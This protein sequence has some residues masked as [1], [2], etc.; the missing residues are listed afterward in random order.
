VDP[1]VTTFN[2][3]RWDQLFCGVCRARD[4]GGRGGLDGIN[5]FR[6]SLGV[7]S[8]KNKM[9]LDQFVIVI[10]GDSNIGNA[11]VTPANLNVEN[12][13]VEEQIIIDED[14]D[15]TI[16]DDASHFI[17]VAQEPAVSII[18]TITFVRGI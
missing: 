18:N 16:G 15:V 9:T 7:R 8:G 13:A 4:D 14:A 12:K 2:L 17:H 1:D 3:R 6:S 11:N 5:E 10:S